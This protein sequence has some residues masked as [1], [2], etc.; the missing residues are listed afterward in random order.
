MAARKASD[1]RTTG[2]VTPKGG[3]KP[4]PPGAPLDPKDVPTEPVVITAARI[5]DA[6][7]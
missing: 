7:K 4:A 6:A 1:R 5:V 3:G 2:R